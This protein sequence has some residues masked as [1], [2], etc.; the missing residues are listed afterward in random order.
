MKRWILYAVAAGAAAGIGMFLTG[1]GGLQR[2]S[3]EAQNGV[4]KIAV[5]QLMQHGSLDAANQG[6]L[7]G[8]AQNGFPA[9]KI[10][11]DQQN[12][13]GDQSNLKSIAARFKGDKPD[14]IC[15]IATPAAQ[16]AANDI[17]DVPIVGI[18]ITD[19]VQAKLVQSNEKPGGNVTGASDMNP[20]N[21]QIDMA[22]EL[23][24]GAKKVGLLYNSSE[25]NSEVQGREM[26]KYAA[27]KGLTV[28]EKTVSSVNDIQ[29][30]AESMTGQIDF[31]YVPTDNILASSMPTLLKM[32]DTARI[33]VI[34]GAES[35]VKDGALASLSVDYY[36]LGVQ[37]G[38]MAAKILKG[39]VQASA[40]PVETQ[41]NLIV[42]INK[43][44]ADLLGISIPEEIAGKAQFE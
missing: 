25:V 15:A 3:G 12:A 35:M 42:V 37:A 4:K 22:L 13:Q 36:Q 6:F 5:V 24:P 2:P 16:A 17:H 31:L 26:K 11:V 23:M 38:A 30:A 7:A 33:P 44:N 8:L 34:A 14:L 20:V 41:Q 39:E 21:R 29:Q 10:Q 27:E 32:T 28:V 40:F 1:C 19:Y 9:D 43:K 18:A